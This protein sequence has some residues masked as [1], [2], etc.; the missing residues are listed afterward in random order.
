MDHH[1]IEA[2]KR[3]AKAL[4]KDFE[5][6]D[7][8]AK[9]RVRALWPG[10]EALS[11]ADA[12]HLLAREAGHESWPKLKFAAEQAAMDRAQ[13][14]ERLK[15]ALYHGQHWVV[16]SLLQESPDLGRGDFGLSCALYDIAQV[17]AVLARDPEAATRMVGP[18]RPM[19]HLCFSKHLHGGG[20]RDAMIEVAEALLAH[21]ADVDDGFSPEGAQGYRLSALYGAL[22]HGDNMPL[23]RWLL[24]HGANP[25]DNESLY[26]ATELG[27]L[28]GVR[29]MLEFGATI[30]GTNALARMLDFDNPEGARLL[31]EAGAKP[32]EDAAEH[33]SGEPSH[34]IKALHHAARRRCGPEIARLLLAHGAD[35]MQTAFGHSAY[36]LARMFG[37]PGFAEVLEEAGQATE[38]SR[39]EALFAAAA[40]G[41]VDG[42]IAGP[43]LSRE[44]KRMMCRALQFD[45][46]L[47]HVK[48]LAGIGVS[49]DWTEEMGLPAIHIAGWEGHLD[50]VE[51][52]L[53]FGPDLTA[54]NRYGGDLMGTIL[55]GLENNPRAAERDHMGCVKTVLAAGAPL[56][57]VDADLCG[58]PGM[59]AFLED[60]A[61]A[62]PE[63]VVKRA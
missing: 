7:A 28:D 3:A 49:P 31:L 38:L 60:W 41:R 56:H 52:L 23:A 22:G 29:L 59:K 24:E 8:A 61:E 18:R 48:A 34:A 9:A 42:S 1:S 20:D 12:L 58:V 43:E 11:H 30:E 37:N 40:E 15:H 25:D 21:G 39:S 63:R 13:K 57:E 5:S 26:H 50:A 33:P 47:P 51:W 27:H 53:G 35:G 46:P 32:E 2:M 14:A 45:A 62:H 44:Q 6:G 17:R 54:R 36:A 16:D 4:R 55:H 10:R 19:L